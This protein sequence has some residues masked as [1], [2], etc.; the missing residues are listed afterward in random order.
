MV[1]WSSGALTERWL[2]N[3]F[4]S[5]S[6]WY[7]S[8]KLWCAGK[9]CRAKQLLMYWRWV[10]GRIAGG[11]APERKVCAMWCKIRHGRTFKTNVRIYIAERVQG[12]NGI[13]HDKPYNRKISVGWEE[14]TCVKQLV[15]W[16]GMPNHPSKIVL[17]ERYD[18][19]GTGW[20]GSTT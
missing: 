8:S 14:R 2:R 18:G 9:G 5:E 13:K 4:V 3:S 6:F 20:R 11:I 16:N 1:D 19:S 10:G 15:S 12:Y 7:A 17:Q